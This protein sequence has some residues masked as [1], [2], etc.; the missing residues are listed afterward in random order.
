MKHTD[1]STTEAAELLRARLLR[2]HKLNPTVMHTERETLV[3]LA[4]AVAP[5]QFP[6]FAGMAESVLDAYLSS[7]P[8]RAE[9]ELL[10]EYFQY[11]RRSTRALSAGAPA[12][13]PDRSQPR[14]KQSM[15]LVDRHSFSAL[16]WC[17]VLAHAEI[18]KSVTLAVES[19]QR[20]NELVPSVMVP[21]LIVLQSISL[22]Q[23]LQWELDYL[24]RNRGHLDPDIVRDILNAWLQ[25]DDVPAAAYDW[26]KEWSADQNLLQQWPTVIR[27]ADQLLRLRALRNW[28]RGTETRHSR[29]EHLRLI[30]AEPRTR[31]SR[32]D[33][34]LRWL[35]QAIGDMGESVQFFVALSQEQT[36]AEAGQAWRSAALLREVKR[37]RALFTP[38]LVLADLIL[39]VPDG[40]ARFALA[41]F[42]LIGAGRQKWEAEL[43]KHAEKAVRRAFLNHLRHGL[44]PLSIIETLTF[45]DRVAYLR[46]AGQLDWLTKQF[47]S[48]AQRERVVSAL[49][50]YY[51]SYRE[52]KLLAVEV[53]KRYRNMMRVLHEDSLRRVLSRA[54][55][56]ELD[57]EGILRDLVAMAA[58]A[59]RFLSHRRALETSVEEMVAAEL[60]FVWRVRR[61]RH[62]HLDRLTP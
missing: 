45:G 58:D 42:G 50:V 59:R 21:F 28:E 57:Q 19:C 24:E 13:S 38:I 41:F 55:F 43:R 61:C 1:L 5:E 3:A 17:R 8:K 60:E 6:E 56:E 51:A 10:A 32:G 20:R 37:I 11:I 27:K 35:E 7:P 53:S 12:K 46:M 62:R 44:G 48:L 29:I 16:D 33:R 26:A 34:L 36:E 39:R 52:P 18:P 25:A 49:A 40:A 31:G 14:E 9:K 4:G 2:L 30:L 22:E 15:A 23:A 54:E 47:D